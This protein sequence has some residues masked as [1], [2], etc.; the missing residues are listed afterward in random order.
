M[1]CKNC[2]HCN[3]CAINGIDVE[4]TTLKKE[5]CC[6]EF[7]N[8]AS[9]VELPKT[10]WVISECLELEEYEVLGVFTTNNSIWLDTKGNKQQLLMQ[11]SNYNKAWFTDK[12]KAEAILK[13]KI[14]E[15]LNE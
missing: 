11:I 9:I 14:E 2:F 3:V 10:I 4:N 1:T 12:T 15:M 8:K 6:G 13:S 7:K 5:L